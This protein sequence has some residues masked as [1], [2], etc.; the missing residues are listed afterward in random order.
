MTFKWQSN[1]FS[2]ICKF[3]SLTSRSATDNLRLSLKLMK[4]YPRTA[5]KVRECLFQ[6][7]LWTLPA[8][9]WNPCVF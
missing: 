8:L 9:V 4:S 3:S 6:F 2:V 1:K 5:G 7:M